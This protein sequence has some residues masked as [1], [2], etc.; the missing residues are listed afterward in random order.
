MNKIAVITT[1]LF[2]SFSLQG[3]SQNFLVEESYMQELKDIEKGIVEQGTDRKGIEL[4]QRSDQSYQQLE[5]AFKDKGMRL[6]MNNID[7]T[8]L[9]SD[10]ELKTLMKSYKGTVKK[11]NNYF[12]E[13]EEY[14]EVSKKSV[15]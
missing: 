12:K 4:I 11:K 6:D 8:T 15:S 13:N 9:K 3:I 2:L 1:V 10:T 14:Q 7:R 5:Q